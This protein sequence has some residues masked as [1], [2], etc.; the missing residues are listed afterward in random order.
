MNVYL[1]V[2]G[3]DPQTLGSLDLEGIYKGNSEVWKNWW[4]PL[5]FTTKMAW[6]RV[7]LQKNGNPT[8]V[9][10]ETS[11]DGNTWSAYTFWDTI[12]LTNVWDKVYFRNT[13]EVTTWFSSNA[14]S[15]YYQFVLDWALDCSWDITY[16]INKKWTT[17]LITNSCFASLFNLC[18]V[19]FSAPELP[20]TTLTDYCYR[21][22]FSWCSHLETPP[23]I[24]PA[25]T[26]AANCYYRMFNNC[27]DLQAAPVLPATTLAEWCYANMFWFCTN[28]QTAPELPATTLA[29]SCYSGMFRWCFSL[30]TPPVL[31]ATTLAIS[32][33]YSMFEDCRGL[34]TLPKLPA[35][36]LTNHCYHSMF[37]GCD[38]IKLSTTQNSEYVNEYRIPAIWTWTTANY[39]L[40][41]MFYDTEWTF[42]GTPTINTTYYTSNTVMS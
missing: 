37:S 25:T 36:T 31:P 27:T 22:M 29:N 21:E 39:S 28:L 4:W 30:G 6:S 7:K 23:T 32:C 34:N 5:C 35:T 11:T 8:S 40:D 33:Y 1:W 18:S 3:I 20:A 9:T 19:L 15:D 38:M 26:L 41:D 10:L 24:L 17:T 16:L 42:T 14:W 12:T 13:S 2:N